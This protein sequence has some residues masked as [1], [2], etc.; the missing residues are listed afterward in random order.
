MRTLILQLPTSLPGPTLAYA[1]AVVQTDASAPLQ[2][3]WAQ[4]S[5]LPAADRQTDVVALVPAQALS[6]HRVELP[7]GMHKQPARLQ[8][9]L[10]GLLEDR[11]LD[12]PAELHI[13]LQTDWKNT[14]QPW[15]AVCRRDWLAAH[16]QALESAGLTVHRIVPEFAPVSAQLQI[17]ALGDADKGW[18]WLQQA[19]RGVWGLPLGAVP[20]HGE[21]LWATGEDRTHT[22]L[23]AEPAVVAQ[24]S[25]VLQM[26]ARLMPPAFHWLAALASGWD[27]AQFD[28]KANA[29]TRTLKTWQ[30]AASNVWHSR[31]WQ[32]ARWGVVA[33]LA[34]QLLGLN[35]WAFKT[36][37]D[38][39]AQQQAWTQM[40]RE[41]FPKT[42]VVVDAPVQMARE[43]AR[44][45]QSSGQL[46]P[47][48]LESMLT[49]LGQALPAGV[50][51][52]Q[53]MSY[54][55]GQLRLP[56]LKLSASE[57]QAVQTALESRGYRWRM[58][59]QAA[60]MQAKETQ[61]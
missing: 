13:A 56:D 47:T 36:R 54:Q 10:A 14:P 18:L 55:T 49:A 21:G 45:R 17:T 8:A 50:A 29:Q 37:T 35:A 7:A 44:L 27:L 11:L 9:A 19:E 26:P 3:Q 15:V 12:D 30:R 59:G 2:V 46:T 58:E 41:T 34:S 43:V 60:L 42:L 28:F 5:W 1:H 4:A 32:P 51:A 25:D 33:L 23:Q 39:Q 48:D 40:L 6:W 24:V 16:L 53:Q 38:W 61:P 22:D 20:A 57:Q 31:T 52:P